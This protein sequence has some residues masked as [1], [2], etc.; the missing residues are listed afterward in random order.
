MDPSPKSAD[1]QMRGI[2]NLTP[3]YN[4]ASATTIGVKDPSSPDYYNQETGTAPIIPAKK[5]SFFKRHK[6]CVIISTIIFLGLLGFGIACIIVA[7]TAENPTFSLGGFEKRDNV[8]FLQI[9]TGQLQMN[10]DVLS[11]INNANIFA[12]KVDEMKGKVG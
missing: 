11:N 4:N 1:P 3:D 2:Q 5:K 9:S 12:I 8:D 10:F 6:I 7:A